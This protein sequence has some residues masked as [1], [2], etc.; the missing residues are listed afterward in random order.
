MKKILMTLI[1]SLAMLSCGDKKLIVYTNSGT[2]GRAEYLTEEAKKAGFDI[3]VVSAG[4]T[5]TSN[6]L[7]A[8]KNKPIADVVFGLN[9]IEYE[10]LKKADVLEKYEPVWAKDIPMG[11]S[12]PEGYYHAVTQTALLAVY[13]KEVIEKIGKVPTDWVEL[14]TDPLFKDKYSIFKTTS[15]TSKAV[16]SSIIS[17]Y[18]D[19]NGDLGISDKGWEVVKNYF[20]NAHIIQGEEDWWGNLMQGKMAVQMIWASG[21]IERGKKYNYDYGIMNPEIGVPLVVEQLAIIKGT[22]KKEMAEKFIDWLGS[23]EQQALWA[24]KFGTTP[25]LPE[26]LAKAPKES[27][28]IIKNLKIQQIDWKF[29]SENIDAWLEKAQLQYIK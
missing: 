17:R 15:G 18:K 7:L 24:Q 3:S 12:D 19:P 4:G 26:A 11:L 14:A 25:A 29:V 13:N 27:Q 9:P 21:A 8:E 6:R 10:K 23:A 5:E 2:N 28:E 1:L 20:G 16:Y 22:Q